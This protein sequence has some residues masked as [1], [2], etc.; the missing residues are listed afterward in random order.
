MSRSSENVGRL[1]QSFIRRFLNTPEG[2]RPAAMNA[3]G[4]KKNVFQRAQEF[5][6][7]L[8]GMI[9]YLPAIAAR[10]NQAVWQTTNADEEFTHGS[11]GFSDMR[12]NAES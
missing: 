8:M 5:A 2:L 10:D 4:N 6:L 9:F 11:D 7:T 1:S 3:S 12:L